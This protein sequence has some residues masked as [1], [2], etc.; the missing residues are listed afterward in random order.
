M[1]QL[2][3]HP[4]P[5]R[6]DILSQSR[7]HNRLPQLHVN[8]DMSVLW[9]LSLKGLWLLEVVHSLREKYT[10]D[11][12][13]ALDVPTWQRTHLKWCY[14]SRVF[15]SFLFFSQ[16]AE[17]ECSCSMTLSFF[18]STNVILDWSLND[19]F[20]KIRGG[21]VS[22]LYFTHQGQSKYSSIQIHSCT[23]SNRNQ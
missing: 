20:S 23:F 8:K 15:H 14:F 6:V 13:H 11:H 1:L 19:S 5:I 4:L 3:L 21:G 10:S 17:K 18:F 9:F 22:P 16:F 7:G 2:K 12:P